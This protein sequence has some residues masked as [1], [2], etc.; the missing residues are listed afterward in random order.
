ML[1]GYFMR[2]DWAWGIE[3]RQVLPHVFYFSMS[4]DF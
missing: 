4:L 1:L 2:F 3:N